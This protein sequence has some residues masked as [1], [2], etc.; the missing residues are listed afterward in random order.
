MGV[1]TE[2]RSVDKILRLT[3]PCCRCEHARTTLQP[4]QQAVWL[5]GGP[6]KPFGGYR[7]FVVGLSFLCRPWLRALQATAITLLLVL[8]IGASTANAATP[9]SGA[10]VYLL[11]GVLNIFSLGLDEIAAKL[12]Q[13]G[14]T[15]TV[16]NYLS[17]ASLADEAAAEYRRGRGRTIILVGHSSGATAL[18]DM[19][20]RLDQL[21]APVKLP[22][23]LDSVFR[24]SLSGRVGPYINFSV[25]HAAGTPVAKTTPFHRELENVD[26]G[27]IGMG[28][29]TI[30]KN[31]IMQQTVIG[32]IDA[33]VF[34]R[35]T[36]PS[37]ARKPRQPVASAVRHGSGAA[38]A[39][40]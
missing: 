34:N 19:V 5:Q 8:P 36:T 1:A 15:V 22:L 33:V 37:A 16:A 12:Q 25:A 3:A 7:G 30:D 40:N 18:P 20:A 10:H 11:R 32:A 38:T 26:V 14:I 4:A 13:Q 24:T 39:R 21:G 9:A 17:W 6:M 35:S 28:H 23:G 27:K 2:T 29:L 31:Q